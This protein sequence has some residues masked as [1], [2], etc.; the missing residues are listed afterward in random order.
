M[1]SFSKSRQDIDVIS[2]FN[3]REGLYF[4]DIGG[5]NSN[6]FT[7]T[8]LLELDYNW[9]GICSQLFPRIFEKIKKYR[10]IDCY[11]YYLFNKTGFSLKFNKYNVL[12][13]GKL[14]IGQRQYLER[15]QQKDHQIIVKSITLQDFLD[16]YNSPSTIDY[17]SLDNE[18]SELKVLQ[19][20]D[21]S[22]YKFLYISVENKKKEIDTKPLIKELLLDNG[23]LLKQENM[24]N[25]NFVHESTLIGTYYY[26]KDYTKPIS[27]TRKDKNEFLVSSSYWDDDTGTF[28]NGCIE[29]KS[30]GKGR[31]FLTH[32][33]YG[34]GNIWYRDDR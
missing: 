29:W 24:S 27:I 19:S 22:K 25:Q 21:F 32:I 6:W 12:S 2:F 11:N 18:G 26:Q 10:K 31:L 5:Y 1:A 28:D 34:D 20:F 23:Y 7:N 33:D 3:K 13:E 14:K 15:H 30:H 9:K 4:V 17:F 16:K 8:G